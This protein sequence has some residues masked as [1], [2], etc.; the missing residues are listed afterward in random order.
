MST[1]FWTW[2]HITEDKID[3]ADLA[4]I[5]EAR[6][7]SKEAGGGTVTVVA[8]G[9]EKDD[10]L[11]QLGQYGADRVFL[12]ESEHLSNY[13]GDLFAA[14]LSDLMRQYSPAA[15]LL[16][17]TPQTADLVA[18]LGALQASAVITRV[19]EAH[20]GNQGVIQAVRP[21][22][23]GFLFETIEAKGL[24]GTL[25]TFLPSVLSDPRKISE[26]AVSIE[27]KTLEQKPEAFAVQPVK[28]IDADPETLNIED[29]DIL[30]VGGRGVG[31]GKAFEIIH[32][33]AKALGGSVA[34]TRPVIDWKDLPF[35][36]QIGQTG[37]SVTPRLIINCGI[38]GANEYT[39]GMEKSQWV[40]AINSDP[41][42]RIFRF[43]DLGIVDDL[44]SV[45]PLLVERL[46]KI[47]EKGRS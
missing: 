8:V 20:M 42:A 38:S 9:K 6:R 37:K 45:L 5:G 12:L 1:D 27:I 31:K 16:V 24:M 23:N 40:I 33:L 35:E 22:A 18:R 4:L 11:E 43:A 17:H 29:A 25:L 39:A 19:M 32:R 2:L 34:G 47:A 30:V 44:H 7:L 36:R 41:R 21:I 3:E 15:F 28:I 10:F 13:H 26:T 14:F 46:E